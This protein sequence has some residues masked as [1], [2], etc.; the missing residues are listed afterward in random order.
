M[1]IWKEDESFSRQAV[2]EKYENA[3]WRMR[4]KSA[5]LLQGKKIY[6]KVRHG[7]RKTLEFKD[8]Q[9]CCRIIT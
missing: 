7:R 9:F 1:K 8:S 3:T 2:E 5:L 6:L 4:A